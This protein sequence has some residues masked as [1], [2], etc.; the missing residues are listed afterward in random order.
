MDDFLSLIAGIFSIVL[1]VLG[2]IFGFIC[3]WSAGPARWA[4]EALSQQVGVET[5]YRFWN[6]CMV[7]TPEGLYV[8]K[9][10]YEEVMKHKYEVTVRNL[11]D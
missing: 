8:T 3:A 6:Q 5:S 4:C 2:T 10:A 1:L 11:H 7:K 9:D